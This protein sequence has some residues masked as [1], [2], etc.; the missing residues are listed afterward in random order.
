LKVSP[1]RWDAQYK[2][3]Y[4]LIFR[5]LVTSCGP[6]ILILVLTVLTVLILR[7]AK[8]ARKQLLKMSESELE[9][10]SAK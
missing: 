8:R 9:K 2:L 7:E 1:L 5:M 10:Y 4:K 3:W 6:N